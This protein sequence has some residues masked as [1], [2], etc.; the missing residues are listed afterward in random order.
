ML[1]IASERLRSDSP[2]AELTDAERRKVA[3]PENAREA[4]LLETYRRLPDDSQR[5]VLA[6]ALAHSTM[7]SGNVVAFPSRRTALRA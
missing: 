2:N 5:I 3:R 6:Q 1:K 4:L 7:D